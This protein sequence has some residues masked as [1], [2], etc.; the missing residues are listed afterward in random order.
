MEAHFA[1][2]GLNTETLLATCACDPPGGEEWSSNGLVGD[3]VVA[4]HLPL[5]AGVRRRRGGAVPA[6]RHC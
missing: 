4:R 3:D 1:Y 6:R 5:F 2:K